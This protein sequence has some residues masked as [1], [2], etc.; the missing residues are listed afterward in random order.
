MS[1]HAGA[2]PTRSD[3]RR[4]KNL[5]ADSDPLTA[6]A[7]NPTD[8]STRWHD[9]Y[10]SSG[11]PARFFRAINR[12]LVCFQLTIPRMAPQSSGRCLA[13]TGRA[14]CFLKEVFD[15]RCS[16]RPEFLQIQ[17]LKGRFSCKLGFVQKRDS[18]VATLARRASEGHDSRVSTGVP[19]WRVGLV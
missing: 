13:I 12:S 9:R 18:V 19:R 11:A 8:R 5:P 16:R 2:V 17:L 7:L 6:V 4:P 1:C 14:A 10:G 3:G 15:G